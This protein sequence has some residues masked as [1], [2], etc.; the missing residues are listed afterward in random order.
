MKY[1]IHV[2]DNASIHQRID[3]QFEIIESS[4]DSIGQLEVLT[5]DAF[6]SVN[7]EDEYT[8]IISVSNIIAAKLQNSEKISISKAFVETKK[9]F[10]ITDFNSDKPSKLLSDIKEER[11]VNPYCKYF[12]ATCHIEKEENV[13]EVHRVEFFAVEENKIIEL[14]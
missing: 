2:V 5:S 13:I 9:S 11:K 6:Y 14:A 8:A 10:S 7:A 1:I 12:T 4:Y 3:G